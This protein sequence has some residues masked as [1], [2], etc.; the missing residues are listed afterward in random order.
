MKKNSLLKNLESYN[1]YKVY[2][3]TNTG[4]EKVMGNFTLKSFIKSLKNPKK[5]KKPSFLQ[6]MAE[7][8][9]NEDDSSHQEILVR[10]K[11]TNVLNEFFNKINSDN[12]SNVQIINNIERNKKPD[13][14]LNYRKPIQIDVSPDPCTYYPKY[15]LIFKRTPIAM[16]FNTPK[17]IG[18]YH[19]NNS[20][21]KHSIKLKGLTETKNEKKIMT[22]RGSRERK[23][24][25]LKTLK[26]NINKKIGYNSSINDNIKK[27]NNYHNKKEKIKLQNLEYRYLVKEKVYKKSTDG[28]NKAKN[29]DINFL[30]YINKDKTSDNLR[31]NNNISSLQNHNTTSK[32]KKSRKLNSLFKTKGENSFEEE[33]N[34]NIKIFDFSKMSKRNFGIIL[35]N[36]ILKNPS[37]YDYEPKFDYI[38]QSSNAFNFGYNQNKTNYQKKKFLLK[39]M[40][41]SYANL[42]KDYYIINNSKLNDITK[43]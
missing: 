17:K 40:L 32:D 3:K 4:F 28:L 38:T 39:K 1:D 36:S 22:D 29:K 23:K 43:K 25:R 20:T 27:D 10:N 12:D 34:K 33:K 7:K 15:D 30:N 24:L 11:K 6:E 16:I 21:E 8:Y 31:I 9:P 13:I 35:N 26:N 2:S 5:I 41:C 14:I 37:V 18:N 42:S 19:I